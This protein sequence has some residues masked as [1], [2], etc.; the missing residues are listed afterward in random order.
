MVGWV[1]VNQ[2]SLVRKSFAARLLAVVAALAIATIALVGLTSGSAGAAP[3][4]RVVAAPSTNSDC[5]AYPVG[6]APSVSISTTSPFPGQTVTISGLN[7]DHSAHV[8]IVM[9]SPLVTLASTTTSASG[10]FSV[11]VTIPTNVT[12]TKTISIV[13]GAPADCLPNT[14]VIQIQP[15]TGPPPGNH[16]SNTGVDIFAGLLVALVLVGVGLFLTRTG[17]RRHEPEHARHLS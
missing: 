5:P 13:G 17:R 14:I 6:G 1:A 11:Q 10:S 4:L 2:V 15:P 9:R 7:F 12:G 3:A 16:L 8:A